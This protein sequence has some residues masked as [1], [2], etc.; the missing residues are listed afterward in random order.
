VDFQKE[1]GVKQERHA[2]K[3]YFRSNR[4]FIGWAA[5]NAQM[6]YDSSAIPAIQISVLRSKKTILI[7][8]ESK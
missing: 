6:T 8:H 2:Q 5:P 3:A 4:R 1:R 7:E